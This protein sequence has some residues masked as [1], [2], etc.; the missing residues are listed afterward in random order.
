MRRTYKND[1]S[2]EKIEN[3]PK[4]KTEP[5]ADKSISIRICVRHLLHSPCKGVNECNEQQ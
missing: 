1:V 4:Q 2:T 3:I 5:Y